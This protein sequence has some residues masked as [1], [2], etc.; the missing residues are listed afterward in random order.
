MHWWPDGMVADER[1][2]PPAVATGRCAS[3]HTAGHDI[4]RGDGSG[5]QA[6]HGRHVPQQIKV[7]RVAVRK[8][9]ERTVSRRRRR[10]ATVTG[11][12]TVRVALVG[13]GDRLCRLVE[14]PAR[15]HAHTHHLSDRKTGSVHA[16]AHACGVTLSCQRMRCARVC[17]APS[18]GPRAPSRAPWRCSRSTCA[19]HAATLVLRPTSPRLHTALC[20]CVTV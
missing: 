15:N 2:I 12:S 18:A 20:S 17:P 9:V 19:T 6:R 1:C 16:H 13:V 7:G 10:P 8:E 4:P 5:P 14:Q 3:G 11:S